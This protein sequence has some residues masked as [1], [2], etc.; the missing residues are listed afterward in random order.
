[1]DRSTRITTL[2]EEY[3][4]L[5]IASQV[6][7]E[8]FK[9]S[10]NDEAAFDNAGSGGQ[11]T[12]VL[13]DRKQTSSGQKTRNDIL[14]LMSEDGGISSVEIARRLGINRSA[15]SKHIKILQDE[16][17]VRRE[18]PAKGGRWIVMKK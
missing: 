11:K 6:D 13:V 18:G 17:I 2:L 1:M 16:G 8:K 7:Y 14:R 12:I 5:G 4:K 10:V 9:K 3:G 15:V